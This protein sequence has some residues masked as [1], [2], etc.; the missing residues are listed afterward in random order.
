MVVVFALSLLPGLWLL[1]LSVLPQP[2]LSSALGSGHQ[3]F[4][5]CLHYGLSCVYLFPISRGSK[6][7]EAASTLCSL[8][9]SKV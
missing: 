5:L 4:L 6:R 9:K 3:I 8:S 1:S 7:G 2:A